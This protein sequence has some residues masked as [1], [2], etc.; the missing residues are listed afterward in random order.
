MHAEWFGSVFRAAAVVAVGSTLTPA[1]CSAAVPA[2]LF[3]SLLGSVRDSAGI[4]QMG[5]VVH[6]YDRHEKLIEKA[7]TNAGGQ[8]LFA[9]L[10]PDFYAVRVTLSSF[11]PAL[12]KNITIQRG[13]QSV[14]AISM[15]GLVSSIDLV[16]TAPNPGTLMSEDWKWVLRSTMTTRPV[17]RILP[18]IDISD[19]NKASVQ[20]VAMFSDTRGI[21]KLSSG[22]T[23]S[24][25]TSRNSQADLGTT[26]ALATSLF[27][28]NNLQV[29]G[30]IGYA[31]STDLPAAGF[32][33]TFSRPDIGPEVKL[34]VQQISLPM[35]PSPVLGQTSTSTPA[36]RTMSVTVIERTEL[37][38]GL[39][40][41]Y[42]ASLDSVTYLDRLNYF[43]PFARLRYKLGGGTLDLGYSSG[44]PPIELLNAGEDDLSLQNDMAALSVLPRVSLRN[45]KAQVQRTEN[46][47][48]GYSIRLG[49]RTYSVGAYHE[50]VRNAAL[51]L[52]TPDNFAFYSGDLLPELSSSSSVFNIGNY[53]RYGYTAAA[54]QNL[55]E[56]FTA[57]LAYGRGGVLTTEDGALAS[58]DPEE[59]RSRI[60]R[61]QRHWA[62]I[63]FTGRTPVT[64]TRF[65]AGY[66]W[67]DAQ[68]LTPGHVYLTQK[69]FPETGLNVRLRQP[70]PVLGVLP[71]RLEATAELRN[72][73]AQGYLPISTSDGRRLILAN[74]PRAVRGGL[75]FI[76]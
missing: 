51:T 50:F 73:L 66:E 61:A 25:F 17:T 58:F 11:V 53:R 21:V 52:S 40:L 56:N 22:E 68:A 69:V 19:P 44:A 24:P 42:G 26:F 9:S 72:I 76:F 47:E 30:N 57:S 36:L 13:L 67:S 35:R 64:G 18:G 43:S 65:T 23:L 54:V 12:K 32:R 28:R 70:L 71:G 39:E 60:R 63:V 6:L 15:T 10:A 38:D 59:L 5:A 4:P 2:P 41:D 3:G 45:G 14:L 33:T 62:R 49:S 37:L 16:Y 46:M 7:L 34:T 31:I 27:G 75:S 48:A 29:S 55:G 8:F 1:L 20:T 74:Y